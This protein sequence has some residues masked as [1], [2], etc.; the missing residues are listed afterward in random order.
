MRSV[1]ERYQK[2]WMDPEHVRETKV[3]IAGRV[4]GEDRIYDCCTDGGILSDLGIGNC[5]ARELDLTVEPEGDIPRMAEVAVS[6]RLVCGS[7]SSEWVPC[8]VFYV[9]TR[10]VDEGNGLL[11]IHG[12]DAML[13]AEARWLD[14]SEDTGEWPMP[15]TAAAADIARRMGVSLDPRTRIEPSYRVEYPNDLTMREVLGHIAA[16]HGGNWLMTGEGKL[17][18]APVGAMPEET[19]FLVDGADGGAIL[20]GEVR[21]IV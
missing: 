5:Y 7:E 8:G 12:F 11:S 21:I 4:Y 14:P 15:Q 1:S 17:L 13:K 2:L 16:A 6:V 3:T 18:L 9:D 20:F 10:S 19:R